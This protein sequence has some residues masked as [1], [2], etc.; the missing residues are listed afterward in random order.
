MIFLSGA[1]TA[2][3][4]LDFKSLYDLLSDDYNIVV[5]EKFGYLGVKLDEEANNSRE[6]EVIIS[7]PDSK[8]K[9]LKVATNE[10]LMIARDTLALAK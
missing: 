10:E 4:I 9:V 2:C 3:P 8:V 6:D 1:G 5:I 7:T